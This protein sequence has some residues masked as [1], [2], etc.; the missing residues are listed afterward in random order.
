MKT[1]F[2]YALNDPISGKCRYIGKSDAPKKR[3]KGHLSRA[4][5]LKTHRDAWI[6]GL[7]KVGLR[8][9]VEILDEVPEYQ[10]EFWE[11]EY[12]R[13]FTA[14]GF[15]LTNHTE[16]GDA[17][18]NLAGYKYPKETYDSRRGVGNPNFGNPG[19]NSSWN[20]G[21]KL[22]P[23]TKEHKAKISAGLLKSGGRRGQKASP[24][25]RA[26]LSKS[27]LGYIPWNKG[28]K[29]SKEKYPKF[30]NR[31]NLPPLPP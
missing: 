6:S 23:H 12:I 27:L 4:K 1:T 26:L 21:L 9:V 18:P 5:Q 3:V 11:R 20:A 28:L 10:W 31:V 19:N 2:I 13:V 24:E 7:L 14:I 30:G 8:P 29:L 15:D 16:G 17:P 25:T 22:P